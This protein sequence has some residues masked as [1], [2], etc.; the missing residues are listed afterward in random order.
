LAVTA[1]PYQLAAQAAKALR[2]AGFVAHD[3]LL[4]LGSGWLGVAASLGE[5]QVVV[6]MAEVPGFRVPV[7][8]GHGSDVGSYVVG[9][10]RVLALTGRTHLYEGYGSAAVVHG[11]RTAVELG[12]R[13]AV[14]T[15]ANG[16]LRPDWPP[17]TCVLVSDHLNLTAASPL[18]GPRF[19]DLTDA[20]SP[21]LRRLALELDPNF[22]EGVYA[23][24]PGPQYETR[25]EAEALARVGADVVGMSTV[26]E[27]IAARESGVEVL[28]LSMVTVTEGTDTGIDPAEVVAVAA[29]S[30]TALGG[31]LAQII[32]RL[33][34]S[35]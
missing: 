12:C 25:A 32:T 2:D 24:L 30:S 19:V 22:V 35:T 15:N 21:R 28:A 31:T 1:D 4:V 27:V 16:S 26:F 8:E 17:G 11:V 33:E 3:V 14:L 9:R 7:A 6:P 5:A 23:M 29:Q 10:K 18:V 20:Y 13:T 34:G